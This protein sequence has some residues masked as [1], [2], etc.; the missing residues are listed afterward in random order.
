MSLTNQ[1]GEGKRRTRNR[2]SAK[3]QQRASVPCMILLTTF[4]NHAFAFSRPQQQLKK[5]QKLIFVHITRIQPK[6]RNWV[7]CFSVFFLLAK[8][9]DLWATTLCAIQCTITSL[10]LKIFY[11][12]TNLRPDE[13]SWT[14]GPSSSHGKVLLRLKKGQSQAICMHQQF[15]ECLICLMIFVCIESKQASQMDDYGRNMI[16]GASD[17]WFLL[18]GTKPWRRESTEQQ[19]SN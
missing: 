11:Y 12:F 8:E 2:N 18:E 5:I 1:G 17:V 15:C 3:Q 16:T 9:A 7:K 4:H 6:V 10:S 19:L 14:H 13:K